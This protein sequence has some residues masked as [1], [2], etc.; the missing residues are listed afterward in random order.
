V[1][2]GPIGSRQLR[3]NFT[4]DPNAVR[5]AAAVMHD[6]I[7]PLPGVACP[8]EVLEKGLAAGDPD[9][10]GAFYA[11]FFPRV[12]RFAVRRAADAAAAER[13]TEAALE[14]VL[15]ALPERQ[16][17]GQLARLVFDTVRRLAPAA[18]SRVADS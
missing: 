5:H 18:S 4:A 12:W 16:P 1:T 15:A 3:A 7:S 8:D 9:A 6:A 13:W 14:A 11:F 2:A 17:D 10:F